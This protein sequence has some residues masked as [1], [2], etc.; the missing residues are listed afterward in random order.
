V[1][2]NEVGVRV[3]GDGVGAESKVKI[4]IEIKINEYQSILP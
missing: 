1:L 2:G 4:K 3:L